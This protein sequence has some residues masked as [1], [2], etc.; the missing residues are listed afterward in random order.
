[1][2][3]N[4]CKNDDKKSWVMGWNQIFCFFFFLRV[5]EYFLILHILL[6][7]TA[8]ASLLQ[9]KCQLYHAMAYIRWLSFKNWNWELLIC[10]HS[11]IIH[12]CLMEGKCIILFAF[13]GGKV[14][15]FHLFRKQVRSLKYAFL[16]ILFWCHQSFFCRKSLFEQVSPHSLFAL[17]VLFSSFAFVSKQN[18]RAA[19]YGKW[20]YVGALSPSLQFGQMFLSLQKISWLLAIR[21]G[22]RDAFVFM[23]FFLH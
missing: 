7:L 3:G 11:Y 19:E 17:N 23:H 6:I 15:F 8:A 2:F 13:L 12:M 9:A 21:S 16:L 10:G 4:L 18:T 20:W 1:M 5:K 22:L 14:N